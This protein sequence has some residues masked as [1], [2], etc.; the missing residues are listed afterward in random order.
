M[1]DAVK[2]WV[3]LKS[4]LGTRVWMPGV[5]VIFVLNLRERWWHDASN[6]KERAYAKSEVNSKCIQVHLTDIFWESLNSI[7]SLV[8]HNSRYNP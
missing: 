5:T 2:I 7:S 6:L 8:K 4:P 1:P 3:P